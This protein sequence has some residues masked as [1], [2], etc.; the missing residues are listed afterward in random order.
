M[1]HLSERVCL[2]GQL[3][4]ADPRGGRPSYDRHHAGSGPRDESA[5]PMARV[6]LGRPD[7]DRSSS[8]RRYPLSE[9]SEPFA[10]SGQLPHRAGPAA[11]RVSTTLFRPAAER[12]T[13]KKRWA[14]C[15]LRVWLRNAAR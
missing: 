8:H 9:L 2:A 13:R 5:D 10:S 3:A 12:G 7:C 11:R 1:A 15:R 6:P 14:A 4:V